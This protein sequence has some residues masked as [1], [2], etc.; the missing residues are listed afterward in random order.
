MGGQLMRF[1]QQCG[2][3]QSLG[4]WGT[5]GQAAAAC[6]LACE[7]LATSRPIDRHSCFCPTPGDFSGAKKS[8]QQKLKR[9]N[10]RRI[11]GKEEREERVE[12]GQEGEQPQP[13]ALGL[14]AAGSRG[15][16]GAEQIERQA[17]VA[18]GAAQRRARLAG[19]SAGGSGSGADNSAAAAAVEKPAPMRQ[20][21]GGSFAAVGGV[22][23]VRAAAAGASGPSS[24]GNS[25]SSR[26]MAADSAAAAL[27][28]ADTSRTRLAPGAV[29]SPPDSLQPAATS[30]SAAA[31]AAAAEMAWPAVAKAPS[32]GLSLPA[33]SGAAGLHEQLSNDLPL[34]LG[35]LM[36]PSAGVQP[37]C[38]TGVPRLGPL[39]S[40]PGLAALLSVGGDFPVLPSPVAWRTSPQQHPAAA[41]QG[42]EPAG[43]AEQ[44][45]LGEQQTAVTDAQV[46]PQQR[47]SFQLR[48]SRTSLRACTFSCSRGT[49]SSDGSGT[50]A[51]T[52]A[53]ASGDTAAPAT[54][55]VAAPAPAVPFVPPERALRALASSP[56]S[57][58]HSPPR[59]CA[60]PPA[61]RAGVHLY[62]AAASGSGVLGQAVAAVG[63]LRVPKEALCPITEQPMRDPVVAAD[64][65]TYE[66]AAI[67]GGCCR[68]RAV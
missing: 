42:T 25:T 37:G 49:G 27:A 64:G 12:E 59:P 60:A 29:P 40:L 15:G 66:R 26:S 68:R 30:E 55:D 16:S 52:V 31:A 39:A 18:A 17:L 51:V 20:M 54:S 21:A 4:K 44:P 62:L 43:Q 19:S 63:A 10:Q 2:R 8:C 5:A 41:A 22:P 36:G 56:W 28:A 14:A 45:Q 47:W 48:P 57:S 67:A 33:S 34:L 58:F 32:P 61:A 53:A 38:A 11:L 13:P 23:A 7:K 1:C 50:A 46:G 9:H 35:S 3:F 6:M 24:T 65:L